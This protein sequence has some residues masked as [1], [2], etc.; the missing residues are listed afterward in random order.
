MKCKL[1]GYQFDK[2]QAI[3]SCAS[4]PLTSNCPLVRC[5]NCN[6]EWPLENEKN[7]IQTPLISLK[8]REKGKI[9]TICTSQTEHLK[10]N[11]IYGNY[12]GYDHYGDSALSHF[13]MSN[14]I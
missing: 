11:R 4:C 6:Y 10:K 3:Q 13:I 2:K 14:R 5:P 1:C 12:A 7:N 9:T 8:V